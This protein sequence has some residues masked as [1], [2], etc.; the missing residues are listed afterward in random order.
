MN[1]RIFKYAAIAVLIPVI[2]GCG[3]QVA[4]VPKSVATVNG[5]SITSS[6]LLEESYRKAGRQILTSMIEREIMLQWAKEEGVPVTDEQLDK[7]IEFHKRDGNLDEQLEAFGEKLLRAELSSLQAKIN[8]VKK[9]GSVTE[10]QLKEAYNQ[11][12]S[13][14][15]HGDQ[16]QIEVVVSPDKEA[17]Q[18]FLDDVNEGMSIKEASAKNGISDPRKVWMDI[19]KEGESKEILDAMKNTNV[20]EMTKLVPLKAGEDDANTQYLVFK[21]LAERPKEEKTFEQAKDE[22]EIM[23]CQQAFMMD[24]KYQTK[25]NEKKK[26]ADISITDKNLDDVLFTFKYPQEMPMFGGMP[27]MM[28]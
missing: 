9:D 26:T 21:V 10:E 11:L 3:K 28:P 27:G 1:L 17:M 8:V 16:K 24:P 2:A 25:F 12:K 5:V 22:I 7:L 6:A 23:V 4:E 15:S 18:K 14:L 19:A 20:G 13:A